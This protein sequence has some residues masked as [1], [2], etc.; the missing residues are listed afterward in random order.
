MAR[1]EEMTARAEILTK[2]KAASIAKAAGEGVYR[3]QIGSDLGTEFV[4][5]AKAADAVIHEIANAEELPPALQSAFAFDGSV[6]SLHIAPGSSLR[7][8]PWERTPQLNLSESI[9]SGTDIA[10]SAADFAI[11]ESGTLVFLSGAGRPSSWHFLPEIE[12]VLVE[13]AAI[14]PTLE[15]VSAKLSGRMLPSTINLVTGP[16]RT[17]DI[18]Q[19]IE[20]G[21]HGPRE[22][23]IFLCAR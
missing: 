15:D 18:E 11:A 21:A 7:D 2:L 6:R 9:P 3:P 20:R 5:K 23:H 22:L 10:L 12:C 17:A 16:S 13:R 19:T 1:E 4:R 8:L 14:L